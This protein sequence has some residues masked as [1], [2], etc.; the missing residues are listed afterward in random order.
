MKVKLLVIGIICLL[1][2]VGGGGFVWWQTQLAAVN[3]TNTQEVA[4]VVPRAQAAAI[5]L[6]QLEAQ[7]LIR[8]SL[9]ARIY[10]KV[11]NSGQSLQNGTFLV[12]PSQDLQTV[13]AV[14][15][16]G[17][18]DI[19][20]TFPE[21]W[22][23]EQIAARLA[24][25]LVGPEAT[26]DT[27]EFMQA[28]QALEGQL[29]PDTYLIPRTASAAD[30]VRLMTATFASK[31]SLDPV[32]DQ[33]TLILA[34][35]IEREGK[36]TT[37]RPIIAGVLQNRL[38][39]DWPLQVDAAVQYGRDTTQCRGNL[40]C[41]WWSPLYDSKIPSLYNTYLHAGLPPGPISNPG[42]VSINAALNP[43][44]TPYWYYIHAPDGT[45]YYA[46]TLAEH[47][48]NIDKYLKP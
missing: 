44:D 3:P 35:I 30:V 8:S 2:L 33:D 11:T 10:L 14:L 7:G 20:V 22:R 34:S 38:D 47:N 4:F 32:A 45:A 40:D 21:G 41:D 6:Q 26:F 29:F 42:L 12:S 46:T 9:A 48:A 37:D 43:A 25:Q 39:A 31:T 36:T 18:K 5:T 23:R 19:W 28:T 17:P 16:Q 13:I 24:S 1:A 27:A 15:S